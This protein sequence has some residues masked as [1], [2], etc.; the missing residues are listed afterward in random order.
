MAVELPSSLIRFIRASVPTYQAAEVLLFLAAHPERAFT[1]EE[2]G[3]SMKP[4]VLTVADARHYLALFLSQGLIVER[5]GGFAYRPASGDLARSIAELA[6]AYNERPVTLIKVISTMT[7]G[8]LRS[9]ADTF[10]RRT[11]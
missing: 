6:H 1:P 2:I 5:E 7:D 11:E 4:T 10:D 3:A 8:G 9:F